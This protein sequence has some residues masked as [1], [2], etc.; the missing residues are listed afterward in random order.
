ML[1]HFQDVTENDSQSPE[2]GG[3]NTARLREQGH[4]ETQ[5]T[6][7]NYHSLICGKPN[8]PSTVLTAMNKAVKITEAK[9]QEYTVLTADLDIAKVILRI[10]W[11]DPECWSKLIPRLGGLHI[12]MN[13]L[14]CIGKLAAD[15]GLSDILKAAFAGVE[16]MLSGKKYPQNFRAMCMVVEELLRPILHPDNEDGNCQF[17]T[18]DQLM[19]HLDNIKKQSRTAKFW[20]D[21][22]IKPTLLCM[23]F[24][25]AEREG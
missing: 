4:I 6:H 23:R 12:V 15:S 3:W 11:S 16:K 21:V 2:W 24:I 1:T 13:I 20:V 7:I 5:A 10:Y 19:N 18:Y 22:V 9:G 8:D 14:G 25:R 17:E